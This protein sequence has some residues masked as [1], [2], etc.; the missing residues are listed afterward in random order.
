MLWWVAVLPQVVLL[1]INLRAFWIVSGE[2]QPW[3]REMAQRIFAFEVLLI[4]ASASSSVMLRLRRSA[5][6]WALNGPLF[7]APIL[8]LWLAM[9]QIGGGLI[10]ASVAAWILPPEPLLYYQF[11]L[12][13]PVIFYAGVR[14]ACV[15]LPISRVQEFG[16]IAGLLVGVP[17][18]WYLGLQLE[19]T[20]LFRA[21]PSSVFVVA[22]V[23]STAIVLGAAARACVSGYV[24]VRRKGPIALAILSF[25]VGVA[26]PLGGL[27]LN[28]KI[29]CPADFKLNTLPAR[30]TIQKREQARNCGTA[31]RRGL[32]RVVRSC[33]N[34]ALMASS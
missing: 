7:A 16:V 14:L 34:R 21:I 30:A 20:H 27:A 3:Q 5:V 8:Y 9:A 31:L 11:A 19:R 10:P 33:S 6:P 32:L 4:I 22:G 13:M 28:A 18:A 23:C 2:F 17:L 12:M 1:L 24:A 25:F 15:D 26:A 29:P